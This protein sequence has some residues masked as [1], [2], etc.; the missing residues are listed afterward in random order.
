M[1][2]TL[3]ETRLEVERQRAEL[4]GTADR[5]RARA[6][7][8]FDLRAKFRENPTL[9]I[10]LGA[11]AVF[12]AVGGPVRIARLARRRLR[13][14]TQERAYDSLPKP[15]QSWV[16]SLAGTVGPKAEQ[17]RQA[18]SEELVKWRHEP[19]RDRKARKELA[20]AMVEG[21]PGPGRTSWKAFEAAAAIL[22]AA[23][24]RKAVERFLSGEPPIGIHP[25]LDAAGTAGG[26][27]KPDPERAADDA[28]RPPEERATYSSISRD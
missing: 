21:P 27:A 26:A 22:S 15:L 7:R 25:A 20:K 19:L 12:L 16:D 23:L 8:T 4:Q 28:T 13:P 24:A 2:E 5:L 18:L 1:G 3:A 6:Q 9:F 17:A 14:T 11:G 10:G